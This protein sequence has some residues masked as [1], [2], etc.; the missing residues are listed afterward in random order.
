MM[1]EGEKNAKRIIERM[2][3]QLTPRNV[4]N[5][6]LMHKITLRWSDV[7]HSI[8]ILDYIAV[9]RR[10]SF[11]LGTICWKKDMSHVESEMHND[12]TKLWSYGARETGYER[13]YLQQVIGL[14]HTSTPRFDHFSEHMCMCVDE[15]VVSEIQIRLQAQSISGWISI[16][17]RDH[18]TF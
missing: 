10:L 13:F 2:K 8:P 14:K 16:D 4:I 1:S 6:I 7:A 5:S 9:K 18:E 15:C 11:N 3:A 17:I 12:G